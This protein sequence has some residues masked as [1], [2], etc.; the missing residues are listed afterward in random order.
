MVA[1]AA[2]FD[3]RQIDNQAALLRSSLL[4]ELNF[5]PGVPNG[6]RH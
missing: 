6:K 3:T 2:V 1:R 5:R 4:K